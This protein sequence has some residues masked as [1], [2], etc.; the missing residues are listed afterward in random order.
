MTAPTLTPEDIRYQLAV[1]RAAV[2][3]GG[4]RFAAN[5]LAALDVLDR[6]RCA[7]KPR[8]E[9]PE[10]IAW[11]GEFRTGW[12]CAVEACRERCAPTD[13]AP[14]RGTIAEVLDLCDK[15]IA[16]ADLRRDPRQLERRDRDAYMRGEAAR[17]IRAMLRR[18]APG[19]SEPT[20]E[21]K[22]LSTALG[23]AHIATWDEM[24]ERAVK[25]SLHWEGVHDEASPPAEEPAEDFAD[26]WR[27]E[28]TALLG[29]AACASVSD[30]ERA[31]GAREPDTSGAPTGPGW[32]AALVDNGDGSDP[33]WA[34]VQ[35]Q[36]HAG[37]LKWWHVRTWYRLDQALEWRG[38]VHLPGGPCLQGSAP[39]GEPTTEGWHALQVLVSRGQDGGMVWH[40]PNIPGWSGP[41]GGY[42]W[43]CLQGSADA[44]RR[45]ELMAGNVRELS[46]ELADECDRRDALEVRLDRVIR[47]NERDL[48]AASDEIDDLRG[49]I[50][51]DLELIEAVARGECDLDELG[52]AAKRLRAAL[53]EAAQRVKWIPGIER[54]RDSAA[55]GLADLR[56]KHIAL[57]RAVKTVLAHA[58]AGHAEAKSIVDAC[59]H[60]PAKK[61]RGKA[62]AYADVVKRLRAAL[63]AKGDT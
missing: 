61:E 45:L 53:V 17:E 46:A 32:W 9:P 1:I 24:T 33:K 11:T 16:Q 43:G 10:G 29:L 40:H 50:E 18:C 28:V 25:L 14:E 39:H 41:V 20:P 3:T 51:F 8:P 2:E 47:D 36:E 37:S 60:Y 31:L 56:V 23:F 12:A 19:A 57:T 59:V 54:D 15:L 63:D 22:T 42:S 13:D 26:Y 4:A 30:V 44:D 49:A 58:E 38:R 35:V 34:P 5:I 21:H 48:Q 6:E 62:E 55:D 52:L 7:T 27:R